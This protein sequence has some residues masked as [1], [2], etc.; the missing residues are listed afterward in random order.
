[1]YDYS[2][3]TRVISVLVIIWNYV[4]ATNCNTFFLHFEASWAGPKDTRYELT[5]AS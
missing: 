3:V 1:M 5:E 4:L 2:V